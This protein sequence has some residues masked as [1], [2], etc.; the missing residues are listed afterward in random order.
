MKRVLLFTLALTM[1]AG[2]PGW[3]AGNLR[4]GDFAPLIY[5]DAIKGEVPQVGS[6]DVTIV[7]FWAT[8]CGPCRKTIPHLSKVQERYEPKGVRI[9][10]ISNEDEKTVRPFV[11]KMGAQMDYAVAV[12]RNHAT[13]NAYMGGFGVNTIPHAFIVDRDGR[14]E[15]HGH[16]GSREMVEVLDEL[17][18]D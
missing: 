1:V 2:L 16:P 8:W 11:R 7:E 6:G 9:V 13:S 15:W 4:L 3:S 18:A 10:G 5:A 12:D 17:T 14:I